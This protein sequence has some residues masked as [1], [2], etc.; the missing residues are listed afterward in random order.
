MASAYG[1]QGHAQAGKPAG[2]QESSMQRDLKGLDAG[3]D[4]RLRVFKAHDKVTTPSG[5][6]HAGPVLV[7]AADPAP[8][9]FQIEHLRKQG[10]DVAVCSDMGQFQNLLGLPIEHWSML[11]IE[12]EGFGGITAVIAKLLML[13]EEHPDLPIILASTR[14]AAHD[15]TTERLPICDS[16]MALPCTAADLHVAVENAVSN[17]LIWQKRL[18]ELDSFASIDPDAEPQAALPVYDRADTDF[19]EAV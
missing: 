15:F 14:M 19:A 18:E 10:R 2:T 6:L 16:S 12:I 5:P 1:A 3:R 7:L 17:N 11:I 9:T 13:R 4:N 8:L